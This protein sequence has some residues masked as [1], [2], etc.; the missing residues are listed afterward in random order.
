MS[1][2]QIFGISLAALFLGLLCGFL[3]RK[4]IVEN[5]VYATRRRGL[6]TGTRALKPTVSE[7]NRRGMVR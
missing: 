7:K 6:G 1:A 3:V 2:I 4:K 5:R